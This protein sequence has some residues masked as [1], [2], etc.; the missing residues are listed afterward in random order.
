MSDQD[1][2]KQPQTS[3]HQPD[4]SQQRRPD[5]GIGDASRNNPAQSGESK[6][7][8]QDISKKN[9]GQ[10]SNP[11]QHRGQE[12]EEEDQQEKAS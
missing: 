2:R 5:S 3:R 7:N 9:P 11:P 12:Q 6:D 4:Q 1:T 10:G 8:R